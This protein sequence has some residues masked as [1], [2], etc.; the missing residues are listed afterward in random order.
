MVSWCNIIPAEQF[1]FYGTPP[2]AILVLIDIAQ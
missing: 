2:C 1:S